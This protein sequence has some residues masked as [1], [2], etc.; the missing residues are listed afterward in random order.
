MISAY[1]GIGG[2]ENDHN[3]SSAGAVHVFQR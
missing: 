2:N 1:V 3:A